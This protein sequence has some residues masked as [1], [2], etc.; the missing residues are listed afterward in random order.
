MENQQAT[1]KIAFNAIFE[2]T[3]TYFQIASELGPAAE[4]FYICPDSMTKERLLSYGVPPQKVLDLSIT[5][6]EIKALP[7]PN[8]QDHVLALEIEKHGPSFPSMILMSSRFYRLEDS[9]YLYRY[10]V[11]SAAR[12]EAFVRANNISWLFSEPTT[13]PEILSYSVAAKLRIKAANIAGVRHPVG[14]L[15]LFGGIDESRLYPLAPLQGDITR[16]SLAAWLDSFRRR[17]ETTITFNSQLRHRTPLSL[18]TSVLK[19]T[20][21]AFRELTG[22]SQLNYTNFPVQAEIFSRR[23]RNAWRTYDP[24]FTGAVFNG[25][26]RP[27]AV[28]FLHVQPERTVDVMSPHNSNQLELIRQLRMILPSSIKLAV[29]EHPSSYGIQPP[30]FYRGLAKIPDVSLVSPYA[31]T[32]GMLKAALFSI[33]ITG[34][35]GMESALLDTPAVVLSRVFFSSMPNV[36]RLE[37]PSGLKEVLPDILSH[38]KGASDEKLLDYMYTLVRDSHP[39]DWTT[40]GGWQNEKTIQQITSLIKR[41]LAAG[42]N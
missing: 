4:C 30:D 10:L 41:A 11:R 13:A 29:K 9:R 26:D 18:M 19:R 35:V 42:N 34:T 32:R 37:A 12:V 22:T 21:L 25:D 14:R 38:R 5:R 20:G 16:G 36:F 31:D 23:Y 7:P 40:L 1:P 6:K 39:C 28:Y 8:P 27:Y 2:L 24:D 3:E 33:T 15:G 17:G